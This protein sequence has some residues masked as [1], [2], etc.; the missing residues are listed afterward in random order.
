[1][2]LGK[3][4]NRIWR[5][6]NAIDKRGL[7]RRKQVEAIATKKNERKKI[8]FETHDFL[9]DFVF[10]GW[11]IILAHRSIG[12][13]CRINQINDVDVSLLLTLGLQS[14]ECSFNNI[15]SICLSS[16]DLHKICCKFCYAY[17]FSKIHRC[18]WFKFS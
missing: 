16:M 2:N 12:W 13:K 7:N 3:N 11:R 8:L 14:I 18:H 9:L 6:R 10:V 5:R 15:K 1:M 17:L 4:V